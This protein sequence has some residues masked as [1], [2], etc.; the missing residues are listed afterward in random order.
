MAHDTVSSLWDFSLALYAR[1]GVADSCVRLQD[2]H[3]VNV[4]LLLWCAWLEQ[5][6]MRLDTTRLHAAQKRIHAWDEHYVIP[7]R[8]L[9]RRMK[10]E[11]GVSD[12]DIE[13]VRSQIKQAELLAEKQLQLW[14]EA[15]AHSWDDTDAADKYVAAIDGNLRFYLAQ[16][17]VTETDIAPLLAMLNRPLN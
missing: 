6:G 4:N 7:L 9:R 16:L 8:Q 5:Q 11:F 1:P 15:L 14:L 3:G 13:Q 17:N 12:G 2:E 10:A